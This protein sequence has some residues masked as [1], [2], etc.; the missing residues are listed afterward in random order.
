MKNLKTFLK[1]SEVRET[2]VIPVD[3]MLCLKL[4]MERVVTTPFH[5][6]SSHFANKSNND[7][8]YGTIRQPRL[9]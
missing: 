9:Y 1:T 2:V 4:Q 6:L 8:L 7:N 5:M 3:T